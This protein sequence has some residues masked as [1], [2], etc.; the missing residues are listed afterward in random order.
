[1]KTFR[2]IGKLAL[3]AVAAAAPIALAL[4]GLV[5]IHDPSTVIQ[6]DGKYYVY[7]TGGTALVSD[8]GWAWRAGTRAPRTGLAPDVIHIG[9]RYYMYVARNTGVT[10]GAINMIWSKS[11]DPASPNYKWEEGGVVAS[12]DG[13]EESN[14]IDPGVFLDPTTGRLWLVYGS[15]F[16]FIR[17]VELDPKTGA[18]LHAIDKPRDLAVNCEASDMMYHD[19][20]YYLLATHGSCCRGAD[21]GYNIRVGR[22]RKVTGPFVDDMGVD[23]IE[24]GGKLLLGSET[25]VIGPGHFGLLDLGDGVQKFSLH[26]EADLERGG[27]SVLDIRPLLW[28]DGW[29]VAGSNMKEGTLEIES[30]RAG[31]ALEMAVEG[32]P[33]GGRITRQRPAGP[34]PGAAAPGTGAPAGPPPGGGPGTGGGMFAGVGHVIEPQQA[35]QVSSK[36]PSGNI[37]LRLSNFMSQAQQRWTISPA[38]GAG[39]YL[40]SPYFRITIAGTERALSATPGGELTVASSF[41]G[42]PEQLW[43]FDQLADG[44]WRIMPKAVPNATQPMALSAVGSGGVTLAKFDAASDRQHWQIQ[45]Q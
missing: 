11:L 7:G 24:G 43:R 31:T 17:Q 21:S 6:C 41:T 44:T 5:N 10:K 26:Y 13:V 36:W 20:W 28:K 9:D 33:V 30:A 19:G 14:A 37:D 22:S 16:G 15:Y 35:A 23:M 12:S 40:G 42:A 8:D 18:R 2:R 3:L 4:D 34:P 32:M 38:K 27:A 45:A 25:R 1:M 29:P 39:G